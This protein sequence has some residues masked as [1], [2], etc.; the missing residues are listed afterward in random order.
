MCVTVGCARYSFLECRY[1][2]EASLQ[3]D[4]NIVS[5]FIIRKL[6]ASSESYIHSHIFALFLQLVARWGDAVTCCAYI[7]D[8]LKQQH[9]NW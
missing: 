5:P 7:L 3:L 9:E 6:K 8:E 1:N 4:L 2:N